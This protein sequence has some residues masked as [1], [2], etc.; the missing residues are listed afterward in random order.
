MTQKDGSGRRT[1]AP[2]L[3]LTAVMALLAALFGLLGRWQWRL[4]EASAAQYA[5]FA[6]GAARVVALDGAPLTSVPDYQ[7][8]SVRGTY[9]GA[10]Q[11]LL[12]NSI[13]D[14][15]DGYQVLTPLERAN[16]HTI[17]VDRGWVP[18]TGSRARLPDVALQ[19]VVPLTVTGRVGRLPAAGLSFG[20]APPPPGPQWPKVTSF[21]HA[22]EL[23]AALG[24]PLERRILLLDPTVPGGY[25]RRWE[26]PGM[27]AREN[28]GYAIQWWAL[29]AAAAVIW[30]VLSLRRRK[31]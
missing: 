27:P 14:G 28:W 17:L 11:F 10:H 22:A 1:F 29:A 20:R 13:Q 9:D 19:S 2:S 24:R 31:S 12:D 30:L 21:P 6:R 26:L 8:V 18:F 4:G 16:G 15:M 7:R 25:V 3:A 23:R 5:R